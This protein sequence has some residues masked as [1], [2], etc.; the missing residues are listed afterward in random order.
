M[1]KRGV[2]WIS[3]Q[4]ND[5]G[6]TVGKQGNEMKSRE[7]TGAW[8]FEKK[9]VVKSGSVVVPPETVKFFLGAKYDDGS[10]F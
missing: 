10:L 2:I 7:C 9:M 6:C 3:F 5:V 8:V 4:D 1:S